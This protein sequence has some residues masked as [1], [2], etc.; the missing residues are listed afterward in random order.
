LRTGGFFPEVYPDVCGVYCGCFYDSIG[1]TYRRMVVGCTDGF[2]RFFDTTCKSDVIT[3]DAITVPATGSSAIASHVTMG[4]LRISSDEDERG[5]LTSLTYV[6]GGDVTA[7]ESSQSGPV[8]YEVYVADSAEKVISDVKT[9]TSPLVSGTFTTAS[10]RKPRVR[11]RAR[12]V[13]LG[14][15]LKNTTVN[16]TFSVEKVVGEIKPAGKVQAR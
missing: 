4:P 11:T 8:G 12:G 15:R 2:I 9:A 13:Y 1:V 10:G 14:V 16:E 5:N 3:S 6:S 7:T